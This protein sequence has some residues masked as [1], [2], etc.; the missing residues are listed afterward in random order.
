MSSSTSA[1][2]DA[3]YFATGCGRPYRRDQEWLRFFDAIAERI[4][5]ELCPQSTMDA[6]CA[7]G[8][9]VEALRRRGVE[10]FGV[11]LSEYAISQVQRDIAPYCRLDSVTKEF[12]RDYDLV[13]CIEV[14]EH[15]SP[16][17]AEQAIRNFCRHANAILFSST[18]QDF[19]EPTHF[20]VQ[21]PEYWAERFSQWGF[22]RDLDFDASFITPWA[23]L[24]RRSEVPL[25]RV[26]HD[27]ERRI[28][29]LLQE[30]R[31]LRDL[32]LEMRNALAAQASA[33]GL[34]SGAIDSKQP[35]TGG[36]SDTH[37]II[38]VASHVAKDTEIRQL[39]AEKKY[40]EDLASRYA[41]GRLM[42]LMVWAQL[43]RRRLTR[44]RRA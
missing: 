1:V 26:I 33:A 13:T 11:D 9:L 31:Q 35:G 6:G 27:Y 44:R 39:Q 15:L 17:D 18:P 10:S 19:K 22:I 14:L 23:M 43:V 41:Q 2:Y 16:R 7:M 3:Y 8:L 34:P 37:A 4:E 29:L 30:N 21:P 24:F 5:H 25:P 38:Q 12:S 20:N 42:R 36:P 40:W 28:W 32:A